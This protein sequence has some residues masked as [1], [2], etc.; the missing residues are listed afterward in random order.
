MLNARLLPVRIPS[1]S[2]D[3]ESPAQVVGVQESPAGE[4]SMSRARAVRSRADTPPRLPQLLIENYLP[5]SQLTAPPN[6]IDSIDPTPPA[7]GLEGVVGEVE[8][9]LLISSEGAVDLVL[10]IRSTLPPAVAEYA[11]A[12]FWKARFS[13]GYVNNTAVR[14]RVRFVLSPNP[15]HVDPETGNPLSVKNRRR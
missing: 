15:F 8:L 6:P 9:M 5:V 11:A 3:R 1:V 2:V 7:F 12:A 13:P 10:I 14:S 4:P